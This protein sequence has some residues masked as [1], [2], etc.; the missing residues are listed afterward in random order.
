ML[1]ISL[2]AGELCFVRNF[3]AKCRPNRSY[4]LSPHEA[5]DLDIILLGHSL[6]G[7]LTTDV[8]LLPSS[9][10][11]PHQTRKHNILGLIN[12]D[13]PFLGLHPGIIQTSCKSLFHRDRDRDP[14]SAKHE[15]ET[16]S[17]T[18]T[19]T[20]ITAEAIAAFSPSHYDPPFFNDIR[21]AERSGMQGVVHFFE[22]N[23]NRLA[24][25]ILT[26]IVSPY[27]FAGCLN[28]YPTLR[29]RY[30]QLMDMEAE[31]DQASRIR[32]VNYY[33]AS[34]APA[35]LK[36]KDNAGESEHSPHASMG[37]SSS[38]VDAKENSSCTEEKSENE[39]EPEPCS[40]TPTTS[41]P[42]SE[43]QPE[44][45][46]DP[47]PDQSDCTSETVDCTSEQHKEK[48]RRKFVL[49]PSHHWSHGDD[50]LWIPVNMDNMN[51][52]T[53]HQSLFLP[54]GRNYD[55]LVGDTMATIEKWIQVDLT[56]R[57]LAQEEQERGSD[58][59]KES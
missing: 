2:V 59:Y 20:Q 7:I 6:G 41:H 42:E 9:P 22:K 18:E 39:P 29:R 35:P 54:H 31:H 19:E 47:D 12:F 34:E 49:L 30:K 44:P 38:P 33:T 48:K 52:I 25:S 13:V 3:L 45:E 28:N 14:S 57:M 5:N 26:R 40:L 50:S 51:E 21:W 46:R 16:F 37:H 24:K 58:L 55:Q 27:E 1:G 17:E 15:T 56:Q 32:F 10:L 53:A 23:Y 8:A 4:R 11:H 36:D 43:V